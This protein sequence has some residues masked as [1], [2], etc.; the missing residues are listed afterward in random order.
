M[1]IAYV[2]FS[3]IIFVCCTVGLLINFTTESDDL[4]WED[5]RYKLLVAFGFVFLWPLI[6]PYIVFWFFLFVF[7][8]VKDLKFWTPLTKIKV[9][10]K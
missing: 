5:I 9:T 10:Y 6:V 1:F 7:G 4:S 3:I 8:L 2:V